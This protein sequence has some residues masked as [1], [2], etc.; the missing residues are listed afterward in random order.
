MSISSRRPMFD[1][2][3][4]LVPTGIISPERAATALYFLG[5]LSRP[6]RECGPQVHFETWGP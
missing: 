4:V 3:G 1:P 5:K 2:I 6:S